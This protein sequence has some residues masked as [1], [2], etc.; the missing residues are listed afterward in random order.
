MRL[1]DTKRVSPSET[2]VII[3]IL[4]VP[5]HLISRSAPSNSAELP[6]PSLQAQ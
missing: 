4:K 6:V 1:N 3:T 5:T 2:I